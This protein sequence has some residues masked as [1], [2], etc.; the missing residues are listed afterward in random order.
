MRLALAQLNPVI[1]DM[2]SNFEKIR[3]AIWSA[4]HQSC[5]L[6]IFPELALSGYMAEDLMQNAGFLVHLESALNAVRAESDGIAVILGHPAR[7]PG[8][9]KVLRNCL[10][11]F[12]NGEILAEYQKRLLPNY[13]VFNEN[14]YFEPGS[15]PVVLELDG[16]RLGL[17]ICEDAWNTDFSN[18]PG[19][20]SADPI[21]ES[22]LAGA[23]V[24]VNIAASP[25][26][27][28]KVA[29][30]EQM[31]SRIAANYHLPLLYVNQAGGVDGT[32][33]DGLSAA[34]DRDGQILKRGAAFEEDLVVVESEGSGTF[35]PGEGN[36]E[37]S[38]IFHAL[39]CGVR[40]YIRKIGA[41]RVHLGLSGGIDSALVAVLAAY[42]V[43][44]ENVTGIMLPS[45]YSSVG[46]VKD[47]EELGRNLGIVLMDIPIQGTVDEALSSLSDVIP[48][49]SGLT[50]EN[51]QAR[52]RGLLLMGWSNNENS[53]LLNT[54]N[55]SEL[56]VGYATIY[57]DMCGAL[58]VIGDVYK[59]KVF[60]LCRFINREFGPT[61]PGNILTKQPSAELRPDQK[62]SD[63]LPPYEVL[64]AIL[65]GFVEEALAPD[66]IAV[67]ACEDRELVERVIG[68]VLRTE[69]KRKQAAPIL[70]ITGRAFGTGF[71]FPISSGW[72]PGNLPDQIEI[73]EGK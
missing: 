40:D 1:G 18:S 3:S 37:N 31:F 53:I 20:Y 25:F 70:K 51:L 19:L 28:R 34:F 5:S 47:A 71:R 4:R 17:T 55:K 11:V 60:E 61:I 8:H 56:A 42:A 54:G 7:N 33:F 22:V 29:F 50:E 72:K 43:G 59:T 58:A 27:Y 46:S 62:D 14:R 36:T 65:E 73:E 66:E 69:F 23:D 39:V 15:Q 52:V 67:R 26:S 63:T 48:G 44:P 49:I 13:D 9:G 38:L 12:R 21:A 68:M 2:N 16:V 45:R 30:R 10:S 24:I 32:I 41:K 64:D 6:V 57:G 35:V